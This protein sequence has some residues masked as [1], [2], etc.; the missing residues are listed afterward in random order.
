M[1]LKELRSSIVRLFLYRNGVR[2]ISVFCRGQ[3]AFYVYFDS[4]FLMREDGERKNY[5][6]RFTTWKF[7]D[8]KNYDACF[9]SAVGIDKIVDLIEMIVKAI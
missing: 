1:P 4:W 3:P 2:N 9:N 7:G 6:N 8:Y 5:Y